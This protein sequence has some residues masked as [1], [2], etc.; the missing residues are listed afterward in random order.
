MEKIDENKPILLFDGVCKLCQSEVQFIIKNDPFGK[1]AMASLQ[2]NAGKQLLD[3]YRFQDPKM[4][5]MVLIDEGKIYIKSEAALRVAKYLKSPWSLLKYLSIIPLFIRN[6][7][8]D[9]VS[10]NRYNWF[11][12]HNE[13]WLPT[14]ELMG[15]FIEW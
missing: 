3:K 5:T 11:G 2:S 6:Y 4:S 15:R 1:I 14:P 13:C 7:V 12:K 8:Y 10:K 9:L